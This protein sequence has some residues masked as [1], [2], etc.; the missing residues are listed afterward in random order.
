MNVDAA[1]AAKGPAMQP[2]REAEQWREAKS[3]IGNER[4]TLGPYFSFIVRKSPRRML[5][6]LSYYKFAAKMIGPGKRVLDVGCS[7]GFGTILLAEAATA[8][9]GVDLDAD[10][11]ATANASV[12]SDTLRFSVMDV[13]ATDPG[14][15]DARST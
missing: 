10:A 1:H 14:R 9:L 2:S 3:F 4:V 12:A 6:L 15:F 7:E 11:V 5:H 13:L 8:C